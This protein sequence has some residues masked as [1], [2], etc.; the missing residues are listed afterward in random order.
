MAQYSTK[1]LIVLSSAC[2]L[3]SNLLLV[4]AE[5][6]T[7]DIFYVAKFVCGSIDTE[8]GPLRPGHYNTSISLINKHLN[9]TTFFWSSS[10]NDGHESHST[11]ISLTSFQSTGID[12]QDIKRVSGLENKTDLTEGFVLITVPQKYNP[13]KPNTVITSLDNTS[14]LEVQAFYTANAL[15]SLPHDTVYE[16]ITFYIIQ[17]DTSKIPTD[18]IRTALDVTLKSEIGKISNTE[19]KIKKILADSYG[20]SDYDLN[21]VEIR[22]KDVN[23]GA[24][25]MIDDHA[26]SLSILK[27]Q[28]SLEIPGE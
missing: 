5:N 1:L 26:I 19:L 28:T 8:G 10:V 18:M 17:D 3:F 24:S 25:S 15:D 14:G 4:H 9:N 16:K 23:I 27:P 21:N 20:I 12:C 2:L 11:L 7:S 6:S 13:S 22:I